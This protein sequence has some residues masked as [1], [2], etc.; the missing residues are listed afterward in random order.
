LLRA[1]IWEWLEHVK[2]VNSHDCCRPEVQVVR[3]RD[4]FALPAALVYSP[5][6]TLVLRCPRTPSSSCCAA[7]TVCAATAHSCVFR[8]FAVRRVQLF[9]ASAV[10]GVTQRRTSHEQSL[11]TS[12]P[13]S[14]LPGWVTVFGRVYVCVT[15]Q[16]GQLSLASLLGRLIEYQLRL[17]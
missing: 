1:D 16:L 13:V 14:S 2:A 11:P 5:E 7:H 9:A 4:Q 8:P 17:G 15:S 6:H 3:L 12:G 10:Y